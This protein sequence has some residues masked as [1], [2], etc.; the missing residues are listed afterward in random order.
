MVTDTFNK[1]VSS[2]HAKCISQ[3]FAEPDLNK[4]ES[5]CI[6]R[7]VS[8]FFLVN[9]AVSGESRE[10]QPSLY[11][12]EQMNADVKDYFLLDNR[13]ERGCRRW[14]RRTRGRAAAAAAGASSRRA[15]EIQKMSH[16]KKQVRAKPVPVPRRPPFIHPPILSASPC[17]PACLPSFSLISSRPL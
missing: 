17:L 1:L 10:R 6:D 15:V 7:C 13:S 9:K 16:H 4:G 14:A 11:L 12:Q 3:R 2:C 5:V 8:K